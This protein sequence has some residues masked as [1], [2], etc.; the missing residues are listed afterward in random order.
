MLTEDQVHYAALDAWVALQIWDV[1]NAYKTAG[2]PLSSATP[3]GQLVSLFV[4]K[5]EVAHGIIV[6]QPTQFTLQAGT[7]STPPITINVSTTKT[8]AV[9]QIDKVLAPKCIISYH[10][11]ALGDIQNDHIS[12]EVVV[13]I[14][15]LQTRN[16]QQTKQVSEPE[17]Q[18]GTAQLITPPDLPILEIGAMQSSSEIDE[19]GHK[20]DDESEPDIDNQPEDTENF[21]E[22]S[23]YVQDALAERIAGILANVFY[24]IEKVTRTISKKHILCKRFAHAFSDTML[25]PDER[26]KKS[27][28]GVLV[29]KN[30]KWEKI[31]SK[32]P[33]WLWKWI[34]Q[35][36]PNKDILY[37]LLSEPS[38]IPLYTLKGRDKNGLPIYHC[39]RGTNSVKGS[40]HNPIRRKFAFLN[41][42]PELADALIADFRH[43]H[44][45]DTGSMH[46]LEKKYLGHYDSWINHDIL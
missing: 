22:Y 4:Q 6:K 19:F 43:R 45:Y 20:S 46:R 37:N 41:A 38:N 39:I 1:L 17:W 29:K 26:D 10:K 2:A 12:F 5:Q 8:R 40:V 44:N 35:Y 28:E 34:R 30:I 42:S 21:P 11:K 14:A 27:V 3:V 24:E 23:G 7:D 25:V 18:P 15:A 31:Q 13:S 33:A 36:I 16:I 9:I 32:S